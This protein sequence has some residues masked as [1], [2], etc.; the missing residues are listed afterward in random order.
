MNIANKENISFEELSN[1]NGT[2][3]DGRVSKKDI[4]NYIANKSKSSVEA[5]TVQSSIVINSDDEIIPMDTTRKRIMGKSV[6]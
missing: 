1:I 4:L 5:K 3:A 6:V 2:G